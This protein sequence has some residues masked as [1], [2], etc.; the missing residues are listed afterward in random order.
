MNYGWV[1]VTACLMISAY[2]NGVVFL[3]FTAAF[4]PLAR[5]FGWSY[6]QISF[7]TSLRGL[8]SGLLVPVAGILMDRWGAKVTIAS[9]AVIAGIGLVGLSRVNSLLTFYACFMVLSSG[10]STA[11]TGLLIAAITGWFNKNL[12]LASGITACGV[13]AGGLLIPFVTRLIDSFGWREAMFLMGIGMWLIPLPLAL[14]LRPSPY[15]LAD[16]AKRQSV[17]TSD[18]RISKPRHPK[19]MRA[20]EALKTALFWT[21]SL[22][23]FCQFLTVG[24]VITHIMP[25]CTSVGI[26]RTTASIIAS[27]LPIMTVV[28]RIGFGWIGDR[29]G[30]TSMTAIAMALTALG[31][32][33]LAFIAAGII[34]I[35]IP[36]VA[37]FGIGWG[38][39][40]PM[41][42]GMLHDCFGSRNIASIVGFAGSALMMGIMIGAPLTGWIY[43]FSGSY[44]LAWF[45][46][47]VIPGTATILFL[48]FIGKLTG[49]VTQ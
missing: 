24:A 35:V 37:V 15:G 23:F 32:L 28:G 8:E 30:N 4:E 14:L 48:R 42:N 41:L 36:F 5:E 17:T 9:G 27:I 26:D 47:A 34:W 3:G 18:A 39:S 12:G 7:A 22:C 38:G 2:Y 6:A 13:A 16:P 19:D 45:L 25:F 21:I 46:L 49:T 10:L 20:G 43:D 40:V 1:L 33:L 44:R 29:V 31:T 11:T